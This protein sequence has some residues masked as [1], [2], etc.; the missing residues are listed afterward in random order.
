M[1]AILERQKVKDE[2]CPKFHPTKWDNKTFIWEQKPFIKESI[3]ELFHFPFPPMI[4]KKVTKMMKLAEAAGKL[5][6]DKAQ[7][8]LLFMDPHPFKAEIYLSVTGYVPDANNTVLDGTFMA[9]V[10]DG[11]F[12]PDSRDRTAKRQKISARNDTT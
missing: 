8:L 10:F 4:G 9:K 11:D 3:P 12:K 6:E 2:C 5:S 7:S 1:E